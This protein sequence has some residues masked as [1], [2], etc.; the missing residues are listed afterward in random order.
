MN[1]LKL[2]IPTSFL[3]LNFLV[4]D[5]AFGAQTGTLQRSIPTPVSYSVSSKFDPAN[6]CPKPSE[7]SSTFSDESYI[8]ICGQIKNV[9]VD[10]SASMYT[11]PP[12]ARKAEKTQNL[13][14]NVMVAVYL[15]GTRSG[16]ADVNNTG[17]FSGKIEG[18]YSFNFTNENGEYVVVIPK[19][20]GVQ[21]M[22][23]LAF[24]CGDDLKDL[25]M[26]DTSQNIKAFPVSLSCSGTLNPNPLPPPSLEYIK[27]SEEDTQKVAVDPTSKE[28]QLSVSVA[29]DTSFGLN[30]FDTITTPLENKDLDNSYYQGSAVEGCSNI[31]PVACGDGPHK[32]SGIAVVEEWNCEK[33]QLLSAPKFKDGLV[34]E[35]ETMLSKRDFDGYTNSNVAYSMQAISSLNCGFGGCDTVEKPKTVIED[36]KNMAPY[37][38]DVKE[39]NNTYPIP[40][41]CMA[42]AVTMS[43]PKDWDKLIKE[44][45]LA[46]LINSSACRNPVLPGALQQLNDSFKFLGLKLFPDL[47]F[48]NTPLSQITPPN[49]TTASELFALVFSKVKNFL[50]GDWTDAANFP[51]QVSEILSE[52]S[53]LLFPYRT[54]LNLETGKISLGSVIDNRPKDDS[55]KNTPSIAHDGASVIYNESV[56]QKDSSED[57]GSSPFKSSYQQFFTN[58]DPYSVLKSMYIATNNMTNEK[59]ATDFPPV[60][61]FYAP[62][63]VIGIEMNP[64]INTIPNGI[65]G[66][67]KKIG[68]GYWRLGIMNVLPAYGPN[69]VKNTEYKYRTVVNEDTGKDIYDY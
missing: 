59:A 6:L 3:V 31:D 24:I 11:L 54:L 26:I 62:N 27:R 48:P 44:G 14:K 47:G 64:V 19:N 42:P 25:Y 36:Y 32:D 2:L 65:V 4:V 29:A 12:W 7:V 67:V 37:C 39:C 40:Q 46:D 20:Q 63:E 69:D 41:H 43:D 10:T 50:H 52:K 8:T 51:G 16:F 53:P 15:G 34:P 68:K 5:M 17:E 30:E 49:T 38:Y 23:F 58:Q 21:G 13:L 9:G 56:R 28:P 33:T 57:K 1:Y 55:Y 66:Q 35:K 45:Y 22:A 61:M 18:L 60:A